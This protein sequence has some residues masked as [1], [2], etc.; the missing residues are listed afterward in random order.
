MIDSKDLTIVMQRNEMADLDER[1]LQAVSEVAPGAR[2]ELAD[3]YEVTT[4]SMDQAQVIFGMMEPAFLRQASELRWLH[5]PS[6]GVDIYADRTLYLRDD[7][8]LTCSRG[9]YAIP[10][11]EHVLGM[12]LALYRKL[13]QYLERQGRGVWEELG[14]MPELGE[15]TVVILGLGGIGTACATR[16]AALGC[17]VIGVSRTGGTPPEGVDRLVSA[18]RTDEVLG[19]ADVLIMAL[20]GTDATEKALDRR[21]LAMLKPN[22]VLINVGRGSAVD[23]EALIEV[24]ESGRLLGAGLDVTEPEPLPE[25]DPLWRAGNIIIT[26]HVSGYTDRTT[27]REMQLFLTN[28]R[29]FIAGEQLVNPVDFDH[30]Y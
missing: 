5:L 25:N 21:R 1:H 24:L 17:T 13:P 6:A 29:H 2:I 20:P 14:N 27:E 11:A 9:L 15:Q 3:G 12:L 7:C 26:P 8:Q 18:D 10:M 4:P 22:A 28:L 23:Q 30:G 16:L 19:E